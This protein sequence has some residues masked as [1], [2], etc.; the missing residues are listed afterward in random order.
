M[1][2][3]VEKAGYLFHM[4]NLVVRFSQNYEYFLNYELFPMQIVVQISMVNISLANTTATVLMCLLLKQC[5]VSSLPSFYNFPLWQ[6]HYSG[7]NHPQSVSSNQMLRFVSGIHYTLLPRE[8]GFGNIT[9]ASWLINSA[10][11][12][13]TN[14]KARIP[15]ENRKICYYCHLWFMLE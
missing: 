7:S 15:P 9:L 1:Q 14:L 5:P 13:D 11:R 12:I 3:K 10:H 2:I 6:S 8:L 4:R